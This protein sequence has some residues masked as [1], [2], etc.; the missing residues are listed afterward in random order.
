MGTDSV[1]W[2]TDGY[3]SRDPASWMEPE[4]CRNDLC[5]TLLHKKLPDNHRCC[6]N[7]GISN[8]R[9]AIRNDPFPCGFSSPD[10]EP[11]MSECNKH[12]L[13]HR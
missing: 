4:V 13:A 11:V 5:H 12:A 1:Y 8:C 6:Q 3:H 9:S 2:Y 7:N 10:L